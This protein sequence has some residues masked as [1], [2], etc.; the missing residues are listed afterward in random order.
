MF[1]NVLVG[2]DGRSNS[3]DAI[4]LAAVLTDPDGKLTLAHVH[5]GEL[6]PSHAITP[7]LVK[8]EREASHEMLEQ[9]RAKANVQAQLISIVAI[10]AGRGLHEQA[11]EQNADLL[12]VGSCAH[13]AFGRAM[14]GDDTRA[15]LNGA[16][17]AVAV[18][19]RGYAE[20]P[21]TITKIGVAYNGSPESKNAL[22]VAREL[23]VP[24]GA[25]LHA[26]EVVSIPT[27]AFTGLIPPA[28]G[29]SIDVMLAEAKGRM[30]ALGDIDGQAVYGL[31]GEEL[32]VFSGRVNLLVVG[33]RGYGPV[34]RLVLGSTTDY[35]ERHAR[36]S[37]L[38]LP[39]GA[40][41]AVEDATTSREP[42][43]QT[44]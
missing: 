11:E 38:V 8:A 42:Q 18:A 39:R 32:A 15:A 35:L 22:A 6:R 23:S 34:K 33:S 16:P 25:T 24:T 41:S 19:S 9:Q 20:H 2:V 7:G 21:A 5:S 4:A 28:I 17:C 44:Q 30:H 13:G 12:V 31:S 37:L 29:E 26:L 36:C 10:G 40:S 43:A 14:L 1:K 3:A 27:I